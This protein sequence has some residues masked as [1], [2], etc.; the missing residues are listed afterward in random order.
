MT[1]REKW[2]TDEGMAAGSDLAD[3]VAAAAIRSTAH[4]PGVAGEVEFDRRLSDAAAGLI[5]KGMP[6]RDVE[7]W[8][9][10]VMIGAGVRLKERAM[11]A[12]AAND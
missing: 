12:S 5:R 1:P 10:A 9:A 3:T 4:A 6:A 8:R 7:I 2:L 11:M